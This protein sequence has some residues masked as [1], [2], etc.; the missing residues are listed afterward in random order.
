MHPPFLLGDGGDWNLLD[1][2]KGGV[3]Q[4][5]NFER[6]VAGR[7]G[8]NFFQGG[9]QLKKKKKLKSEILNDKKSL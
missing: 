8:G 1:F 5:L 3:W 4:C 6:G 2:Q 7:K 9:L